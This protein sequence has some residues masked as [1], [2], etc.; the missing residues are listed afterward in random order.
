MDDLFPEGEEGRGGGGEVAEVLPAE[1]RGD[2]AR[3][4]ADGPGV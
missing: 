1:V 2:E 4:E 3:V